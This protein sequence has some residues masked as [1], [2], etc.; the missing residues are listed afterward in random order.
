MIKS[1]S[2]TIADISKKTGVPKSTLRYWSDKL[3]AKIPTARS[4]K[5]EKAE[6]MIIN[7]YSNTE[8]I[9]NLKV[10]ASTLYD[11]IKKES[12]GVIE[13]LGKAK[14]RFC[15]L[16]SREDKTRKEIK[17]LETLANVIETLTRAEA[18]KTT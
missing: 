18:L 3:S 17:E 4:T 9:K 7:G 5:K 10:P 15:L 13:P 8:I 16:V 14:K 6:Q 2:F 11:W 1:E 12:W